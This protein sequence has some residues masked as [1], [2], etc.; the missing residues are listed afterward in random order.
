MPLNRR[1]APDF[2]TC[3]CALTS[4][5]ATNVSSPFPETVVPDNGRCP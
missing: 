2:P 5:T 4:Q 3:E 1:D